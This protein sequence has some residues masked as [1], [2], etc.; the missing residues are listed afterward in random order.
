MAAC[1]KCNKSLTSTDIGAT[2]KFIDR[3]AREYLCV[4]CIAAKFKVSEEYMLEKI[5]VLR[6]HGCV[7]FR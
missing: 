4:G 2:Q 3:G 6:R 5:D 7:L 1:S